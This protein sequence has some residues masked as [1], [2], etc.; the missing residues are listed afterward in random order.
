[1]QLHVGRD[2]RKEVSD[3]GEDARGSG[4]SASAPGHDPDDVKLAGFGFGG[5]DER[6]A[7]VAHA[8]RVVIGSESDHA[9]IDHVG[10]TGL[11]VR[12]L[13]DLSLELLKSV[14][15]VSRGLDQTPAGE[16]ASLCAVVVVSG[17]GHAGGTGVGAGEVDLIGQFDQGNVV[18]NG[19]GLVELRVHDDLFD[20]HV[21]FGSVVVLLVPFSNTDAEFGGVLGGAEAVGGAKDPARGD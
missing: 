5:A 16:P 2:P 1:M 17:I 20:L 10:P 14:G 9:G 8:G 18:L 6:S 15:H 12:I 21:F 7:G 19:V 13:P 3:F 11:Q 4:A